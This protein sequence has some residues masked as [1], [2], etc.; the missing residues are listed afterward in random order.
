MVPRR[1][2]NRF[3]SYT[4]ALGEKG[5]NRFSKFMLSESDGERY[6]DIVSILSED[7]K[8]A[9]ISFKTKNRLVKNINSYFKP[10][11]NIL[12]DLIYLENKTTLP[13]NLLMKV[14]KMTMAASVEAR[15]PFLDHSL[16]EYAARTDPSLKLR[17]LKD[18]Y[19][20]RRVAKDLLPK[21]ITKRK[22]QRFFVPID[23]WLRERG[24]IEK[25]LSKEEIT[26]QGYFD[27]KYIE[28]IFKN[29]DKSK[30][31]Y[32]RQLWNLVTFQLWHK[33]F[34]EKEKIKPLKMMYG[35]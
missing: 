4:S 2:L 30:L 10:R 15:V 16:V 23:N 8:K 28:K 7:E 3:F 35:L 29:F 13:N 18:K 31:Y 22:K 14:D 25:I 5:M 33:L 12:N 19:I 6:L 20:I 32:S 1:L 26:K 11:S 24:F 27:Y 17:F 34:I 9:L 21:A